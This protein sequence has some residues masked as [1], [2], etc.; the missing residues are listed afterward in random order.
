MTSAVACIHLPESLSG[1]CGWLRYSEL[2][3]IKV[4]KQAR[5][6]P[7]KTIIFHVCLRLLGVPPR[8]PLTEMEDWRATVTDALQSTTF[9]LSSHFLQRRTAS[10]SEHFVT[11]HVGRHGSQSRI[12]HTAQTWS[13]GVWGGSC[14]DCRFTHF[15]EAP[16]LEM[17]SDPSKKTCIISFSSFSSC[18]KV[19]IIASLAVS[20]P[21][22]Q[23]KNHRISLSQSSPDK[24][25]IKPW[26]AP[27]AFSQTNVRQLDFLVPKAQHNQC[28]HRTHFFKITHSATRVLPCPSL[29][30]MREKGKPWL[31]TPTAVSN[32]HKRHPRLG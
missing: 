22:W 3:S 1:T 12:K 30:C 16:N 11:V 31:R 26:T 5:G 14:A 25:I 8:P 13:P 6:R 28:M 9:R 21:A 19:E 15:W 2:K 4:S 10:D 27:R 24:L 29:H 7:R 20:L 17:V 23:W 18:L 32:D